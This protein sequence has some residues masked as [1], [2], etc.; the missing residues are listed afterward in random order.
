MKF[1]G[2]DYDGTLRIHPNDVT[3]EDKQAIKDFQEAGN[4]FA[5]VTGRPYPAIKYEI[6]RIGV[7]CDYIIC[8]N[9]AAIYKDNQCL[10]I[11]YLDINVAN[12]VVD[13]IK[14]SRCTWYNINNGVDYAEEYLTDN[15]GFSYGDIKTVSTKLLL[16]TGVS[17]MS[18][19]FNKKE[20]R[21]QVEMELRKKYSN[22]LEI[23]VAGDIALDLAPKGINKSFA[24]N[25][26][27]KELNCDFYVIGDSF[28]D[29]Q[30]II[31]FNS[32]AMKNGFIE[33]QKH[34]DKVVTSVAEC[35]YS[36]N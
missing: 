32:F 31:D 23:L 27:K 21:F 5:I 30:M 16:E 29:L 25:K 18:L 28:N 14:S 2:S 9:G 20:D 35:I 10:Q 22:F 19:F 4:I 17:G 12:E 34:A 13:I 7:Y 24:L 36:L 8:S 33:L 26:I 6:D 11:N 15:V 3:D 1:L